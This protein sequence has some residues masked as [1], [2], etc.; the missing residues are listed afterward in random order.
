[1]WGLNARI[2]VITS[3]SSESCGQCFRV[4]SAVF[5]KTE[6]VS[7]CE[8]LVRAIDPSGCQKLLGANYTKRFAELIADQILTTVAARQRQ[9]RSLD[10]TPSSKPRNQL[11]VFVIRMRRDP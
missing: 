2:T 3:F 9:I 11:S 8:V 6:I 7:P 1:M 10:A 5:E 4:S